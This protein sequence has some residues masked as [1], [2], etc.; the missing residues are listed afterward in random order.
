MIKELEKLSEVEQ[1]LLLKAP[2]I[3]SLLAAIGVGE[4]NEWEKADAIKLAHLKTYTADPLLIPYYKEVDK[5]FEKDFETL[6]T[7]YVP[8]DDTK[9]ALLQSEVDQVNKVIDQLDKPFAATLHKSLLKYAD[10]VKNAYRG[11]VMNFIFPFSIPGL[12]K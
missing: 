9:R 6:A 11:L 3:V 8:F 4:V 1:E 2:A 7:K 12:T 10:H 5:S